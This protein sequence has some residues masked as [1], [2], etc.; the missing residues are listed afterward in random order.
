MAPASAR[1]VQ[2]RG[3]GFALAVGG[4]DFGVKVWGQGGE[5]GAVAAGFNQA[6]S[7]EGLDLVEVPDV[8]QDVLSGAAG[9]AGVALAGLG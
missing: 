1:P 4:G 6:C 3:E 8:A 9:H 5:G 7:G 2:S